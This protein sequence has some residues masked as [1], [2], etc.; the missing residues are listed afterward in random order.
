MP[1][2]PR[3]KQI[4]RADTARYVTIIAG[5]IAM[6]KSTSATAYTLSPL[7]GVPV[8]LLKSVLTIALSRQVRSGVAVLPSA[9]A[10]ATVAAQESTFRALY[11]WSASQRVMN[12]A[13]RSKALELEQQFFN[14]H[15]A[16]VTRRRGAAMAVDKAKTKYGDVLGWYAKM[17]S[18]TSPE[19]RAANGKNFLATRIPEIG[20]PGAVHPNCRCKPGRKHATSLSVYGIKMKVA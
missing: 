15:I 14:Q 11:V 17:D 2:P 13:D 19:C 10:S 7:I 18:R 3:N 4:S 16:A 12:A 8:G 5:A 6:N 20:Y 9:T 1:A